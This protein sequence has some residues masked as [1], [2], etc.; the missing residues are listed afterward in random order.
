MQTGWCRRGLCVNPWRGGIT[1]RAARGRAWVRAPGAALGEA[2]L[3]GSRVPVRDGGGSGD[4]QRLPLAGWAAAHSLKGPE[5]RHEA[6][7]TN[8]MALG[9]PLGAGRDVTKSARKKEGAESVPR[10]TGACKAFLSQDVGTQ[11]EVHGLRG[12]HS[13][14]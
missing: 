10:D 1:G 2:R 8:P 12:G 4:R 14:G 6:S 5:A 7:R 13:P 9:W 3:L 11:W